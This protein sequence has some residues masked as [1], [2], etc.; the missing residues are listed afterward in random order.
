MGRGGCKL[1]PEE[2]GRLYFIIGV[3]SILKTGFDDQLLIVGFPVYFS[4]V[5]VHRIL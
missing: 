3:K 5:G 2:G 4:I 1:F